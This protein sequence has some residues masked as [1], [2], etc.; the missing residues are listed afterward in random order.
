MYLMEEDIM[1]PLKRLCVAVPAA[2][3][4]LKAVPPIAEGELAPPAKADDVQERAAIRD[5]RIQ[6]GPYILSQ[7]APPAPVQAIPPR[8]VS[9]KGTT[10]RSP[11]IGGVLE[12]DYRY[13]WKVNYTASACGAVLVDPRWVLTAAHCV[14]GPIG[15]GERPGEF[16]PIDPGELAISR[17]DPYTGA[18]IFEYHAFVGPRATSGVFVHPMY[19]PKTAANDIALLKL[20]KPLTITHF[21]Q[22]VA[23]P[24][25][26]R[27]QGLE[28]AYA[29]FSHTGPLPKGQVAV[30]RGIMPGGSEPSFDVTAEGASGC[31]GDSGS[32]FVTVE[33]GRATVRGIVRE[34]QRRCELSTASVVFTD[35]FTHHDWILQTIGKNDAELA[36]NTR[37]RW[38]GFEAR[39]VMGVEC[40]PPFGTGFSGFWEGPLNVVGVE[41]GAAC[42]PGRKQ[43]LMCRLDPD[44]GNMGPLMPR[45]E[46]VTMK[47]TM[48]D[49]TSESR[50]FSPRTHNARY[51]FTFPPDAALREFICQIGLVRVP[52]TPT[53]SEGNAIDVHWE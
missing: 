40:P 51:H 11:I 37:V 49:G 38:T 8:S 32:G 5:R 19:T 53:V 44:Q 17:T 2:L 24:T 31:V 47:T 18:S 35:V 42:D 29:H 36:G 1:N 28:G 41:V 39:G 25:S 23:V 4:I 43:T 15:F 34:G 12:P 7:T 22:T 26:P 3:F 33:N 16:Y 20:S 9:T 52:I 27:P 14:S 10:D 13:P 48:A 30:F 45:L 46:G 6:S 21:V 50:S